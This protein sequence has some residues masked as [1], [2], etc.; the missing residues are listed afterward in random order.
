VDESK[1]GK[2]KDH[3]GHPVEG[4]WVVGGVERT[5]ARKA[6]M[7]VVHNRTAD[8]LQTIARAYVLPG[9]HVNTDCWAGYNGLSRMEGMDYDHHPVNHER[10]FVDPIDGTHTNRIEGKFANEI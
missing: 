5:P 6:F 10:H 1:F 3:R 7:V 4:V 2:R 9:S 8:T